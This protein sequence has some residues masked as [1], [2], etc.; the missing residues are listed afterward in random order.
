MVKA[1]TIFAVTFC[2][3]AGAV[4]YTRLAA[5]SRRDAKGYVSVGLTSAGMAALGLWGLKLAVLDSDPLTSVAWVL[6]TAC[7]AVAGLRVG[8][9][10]SFVK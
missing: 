8:N 4:W 7:G 5:H 9:A 3:E 1:L 6:G 2:W 10:N